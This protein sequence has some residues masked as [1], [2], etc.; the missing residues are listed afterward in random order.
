MTRTR[1]H[2]RSRLVRLATTA[3]AGAALLAACTTAGDDGGGAASG[4]VT[5][6]GT[7]PIESLD[8][9]GAQGASTGTQLA[10]QEIFSRL[11]RPEADGTL[12][13]D[14]ATSWKANKDVTAWTFT[15][16]SG[17]TFSDGSALD[18]DD[19]VA[20]FQRMT[21]LGGPNAGNFPGDTLTKVSA[22]EVVLRSPAPDASVP[23][24]LGTFYVLPSGVGKDDTAFFNH[25]VGSGP[26]TVDAFTPSESLV[27]VPNKRYRGTRPRL[28]K[29]TVRNIPELAARMTAL[30]TGEVDVV[31]GIPDDQLAALKGRQDLTVRTVPSS[32]EFTMWF[33][34]SIPALKD[35][36]V[37]R[38]IW[39]AVDFGTII[40]K[41]YPETGRA[42][43]APVTGVVLG[44]VAQPA[45]AYD[46]TAA[47][48][49][50]TAAGFD[51]S[52]KLRLQFANDEFRPFVQAVVS[53]L[54]KVGV[55]VDPLEK[56][57][58]VFTEDLLALKWD[59]NFQQL[60]TPS[61]DAASNLG[62][63]Y[64]CAARRMGYCDKK[65]DALLAAAGATADR[66]QRTDLYGRAER[67][68]W[69]DAVGMYP[70]SVSIAYAWNSD[71]KGFV[72]DASGLPDF[73]TVRTGGS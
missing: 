21:G 29:V 14:L 48:A 55:R 26:F 8:P 6:A 32:A 64:T 72:P 7:Y 17:V 35:A 49:A 36:K 66:Q 39:Q 50:L 42:A 53:D 25:P 10:A 52:T 44:H 40:G 58:A 3:T 67:I 30:R 60:A 61:Y 46:P 47:K 62:R 15:L 13:G 71:L 5:V 59:I 33:N 24:K 12:E 69:Q 43:D 38:A 73:A 1:E 57:Q 63:L 56:E 54:Q 23:G 41:L 31:W 45:V 68:I 19:V 70:M 34:S 16:R 11:V 28:R 51:F 37:R 9:H 18:A 2:G 27:L 20:S 4:D 65:L 22:T